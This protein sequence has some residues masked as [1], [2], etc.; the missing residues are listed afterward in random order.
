MRWRTLQERNL[1]SGGPD[2]LGATATAIQPTTALA[3][4]GNDQTAIEAPCRRPALPAS[5][6][7]HPMKMPRER[8]LVSAE[9]GKSPKRF[10]MRVINGT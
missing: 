4:V 1:I 10:S 7:R 3:R 5:W 8:R 9:R 2:F 6:S